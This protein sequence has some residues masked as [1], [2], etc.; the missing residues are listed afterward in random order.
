MSTKLTDSNT[1][2]LEG[3]TKFYVPKNSVVQ[4]PPPRTPVFFNTM[5]KFERNLLIS[6]FNSY[7]SQSSH[8][9]TFSDTLSGVGATGLR[10]ANES[11]YVQKIYFNDVNINA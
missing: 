11:N 4:T 9:L 8:K 7:A 3:S 6:I 1:L 5:A 10:L 2:F